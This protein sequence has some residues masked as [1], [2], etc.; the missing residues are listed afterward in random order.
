LIGVNNQYRGYATDQYRREFRTLLDRSIRYAGGDTSRVF[1]LS[2]PDY[3]VTPFARNRN[4][5][6]IGAELDL[7]N[8]IADSI[9]QSYNIPF[10][11]ITEASRRALYDARLIASDSLHPSGVMY[12]EWVD[13]AYET[14]RNI[15]QK[16]Q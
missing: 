9:S 4:P 12:R 10:I 7:Y 6:K 3:G 13:A 2:I 5:E 14:A 15:L 16:Q 1:V 8:S 11:E